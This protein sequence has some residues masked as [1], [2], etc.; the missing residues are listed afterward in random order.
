MI[1]ELHLLEYN[2]L[3]LEYLKCLESRPLLSHFQS[4]SLK[5]F[6]TPYYTK[7][8]P[9]PDLRGYDDKSISNE[10]ITEVFTEFSEKTRQGESDEYLR[11]LSGTQQQDPIKNIS[12]LAPAKCLSLDHTFRAAAKATVTDSSKHD[13]KL[14]NG[15]IVSTVNEGTEILGWVSVPRPS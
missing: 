13:T 11:T 9:D 7:S 15:G 1:I 6:S 10:M 12:D 3:R 2:E 5:P 4:A 14:M 8:G